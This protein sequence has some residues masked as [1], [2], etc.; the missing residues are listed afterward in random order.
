M[1]RH[2]DRLREADRQQLAEVLA[3]CSE[4]EAASH[5]VRTFAEIL[6]TRFGQHLE[7]WIATV[8]AE[9]LPDWRRER[10]SR[11]SRGFDSGHWPGT[12]F[13]CFWWSWG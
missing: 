5:L 4:L 9:D 7:G 2:P 3:R 12:L 6:T 10:S 8:R 11:R 1:M 13:S